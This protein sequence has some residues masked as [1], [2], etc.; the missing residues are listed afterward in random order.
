MRPVFSSLDRVDIIYTD[1]EGR[2]HWLQSDHRSPEA[3]EAEAELSLLFALI[4]VLNPPRDFPEDEP[5]PVLEYRC[6]HLPPAFLR[7]AIAGGGAQLVVDDVVPYDDEP[8]DPEV[9]ADLGF[10]ALAARVLAEQGLVCDL[11]SLQQL[12]RQQPQIT[13]EDD[14][15]G[16]WRAV[17]SLA[18]VAGELLRAE[19]G[20]RWALHPS[21]GTLPFNYLLGPESSPIVVN[22]LGK[23]IKLL[24]NGLEDSLS[25]LVTVATRLLH[26]Q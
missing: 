24:E 26:A 14:E 13:R 5:E 18:A 10:A 2:S 15:I 7:A 9:L 17:L 8:P 12:E 6:Q 23:A 11:A 1:L 22:P 3:I 21:T 16:Y 19:A 20:G 25:D 4:R